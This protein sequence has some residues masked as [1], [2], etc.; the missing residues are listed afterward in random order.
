[1]EKTI[2]ETKIKDDE[3]FNFS[4]S[5]SHSRGISGQRGGSKLGN[6]VSEKNSS[7]VNRGMSL[8]NSV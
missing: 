6:F 5:R 3:D 1:M 4:K 2:I 7:F 8:A